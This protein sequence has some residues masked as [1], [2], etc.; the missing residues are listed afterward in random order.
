MKEC[1]PEKDR[2]VLKY[3]TVEKN[4]K[5]STNNCVVKLEV[6]NNQRKDYI[7]V[8]TKQDVDK[9]TKFASKRKNTRLASQQPSAP[10]QPADSLMPT[11]T[12]V[13]SN[14]SPM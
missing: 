12:T 7:E 13:A 6:P 8:K 11:T 1:L 3:A 4:L 9:L 5:V 10:Q 14:P 2:E